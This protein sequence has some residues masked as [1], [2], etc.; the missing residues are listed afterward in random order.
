MSALPE[1]VEVATGSAP[2]AAVIWLHGL[3][4]DGYDFVPV[5]KELE[6]NSLPGSPGGVRFIFPHA[7]MRPVTINGGMVMRAWYDIRQ[8]DLGRQEDEAGLRESQA[9]AQDLIEREVGRGIARK[10][11]V[12]AGFSQGGAITLQAGLRQAEPLAGLMVL[13]SY[14]PLAAKLAAE[15][16]AA[17]RSQP[18]FMAHG[19]EDA[20]V[21]IARAQQSRDAL[22]AQGVSVEWHDYAMEHSVCLDEL[23]EIRAWL[24]RVLT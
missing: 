22:V 6:V 1:C 11:I 12:L 15:A 21:V 8:T 14:L 24:E 23:R 9:V 3:G 17:G 18:V 19:R 10:R 20:V 16:T 2:G 5:V 13:S 4:A 7:P